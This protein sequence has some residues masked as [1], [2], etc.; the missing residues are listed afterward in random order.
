MAEKGAKY[1]INLQ[2]TYNM[3]HQSHPTMSE[4]FS[5]FSL[6]GIASLVP[7][8]HKCTFDCKL[9]SRHFLLANLI[10]VC[11][12]QSYKFFMQSIT[13]VTINYLSE[14]IRYF[15]YLM[16]SPGLVFRLGGTGPVRLLLFRYLALS[17]ENV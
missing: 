15:S 4:A 10:E 2:L 17:R 12:P 16:I 9:A 7:T 8:I 1:H 3:V 6:L 13:S 5:L 14:E 11:S